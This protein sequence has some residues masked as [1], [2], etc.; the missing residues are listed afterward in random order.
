SRAWPPPTVGCSPPQPTTTCSTGRSC[1]ASERGRCSPPPLPRE[2][3]N[4]LC[5]HDSGPRTSRIRG[6]G[7]MASLSCLFAVARDQDYGVEVAVRESAGSGDRAAVVDPFA[8][9]HREVAAERDKVVEV[10]HV[11]A[12]LPEEAVLLEFA[13]AVS[14][15][16][17]DLAPGV[18]RVRR[19]AGV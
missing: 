16:A 17:D 11:A 19:A 14:R 3:T 9:D 10:D 12:A 18:H 13:L 2:S 4:G 6:G 7:S 15:C 8:V 5:R 1:P